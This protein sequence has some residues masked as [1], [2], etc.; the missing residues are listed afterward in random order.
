MLNLQEDL[1]MD[2]KFA[3]SA[4]WMNWIHK[5]EATPPPFNLVAIVLKQLRR[6]VSIAESFN[7]AL[8]NDW[9]MRAC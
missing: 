2:W 8:P 9:F 4:V 6:L 5:E 7:D 3:R 1:D